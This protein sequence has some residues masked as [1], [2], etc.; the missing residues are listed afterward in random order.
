MRTFVILFNIKLLLALLVLALLTS[1]LAQ[2]PHI[3]Q[4][5]DLF[6]S[7]DRV[8][9]VGGERIDISNALPLSKPETTTHGWRGGALDG[10]RDEARMGMLQQAG[11]M[12][13]E[14]MGSVR[15]MMGAAYSEDATEETVQWYIAVTDGAGLGRLEESSDVAIGLTANVGVHVMTGTAAAARRI[16]AD[17]QVRWVGPRPPHHKLDST[18]RQF[19]DPAAERRANT[20]SADPARKLADAIEASTDALPDYF[21]LRT[22]IATL[23]TPHTHSRGASRR[24]STAGV[25]THFGIPAIEFAKTCAS[26]FEARGWGSTVHVVSDMRISIHLD[27]ETQFGGRR[28][29]AH[30]R[31]QGEANG[32]ELESVQSV[33]A[34]LTSRWEVLVC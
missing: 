22:L 8:I 10:V 25:D 2:A 7:D 32:G 27:S 3:P 16:A 5:S 20:T 34:W 13:S 33:V 21:A 4:T 28:R 11:A 23:V 29:Q 15:R 14:M 24:D 17:A 9:R 6:L 18:L 1:A 19:A 12:L 26:E 31:R 30:E